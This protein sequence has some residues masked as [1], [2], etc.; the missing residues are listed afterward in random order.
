M[1]QKSIYNRHLCME[2]MYNWNYMGYFV[3]LL[4]LYILFY[5]QTLHLKV[6]VLFGDD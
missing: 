4:I 6:F 5:I 3:L 1:E 2:L